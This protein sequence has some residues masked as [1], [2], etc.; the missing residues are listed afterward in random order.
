MKKKIISLAAVMSMIITLVMP[1]A[2]YAD[3][4][5]EESTAVLKY[6][7][8]TSDSEEWKEVTDGET[9]GT[10][11]DDAADITK[12][13]LNVSD[14]KSQE[15]QKTVSYAVADTE[16]TWSDY[17]AAGQE[18]A[19]TSGKAV[20]AVK[21]KVADELA[22]KYDIYYRAYVKAEENAPGKWL[23]WAKNDQ[24][25]GVKGYD[26][27]IKAIQFQLVEKDTENTLD[28]ANPFLEKKNE[29]PEEPTVPTGTRDNSKGSISGSCCQDW[30]AERS[31]RWCTRRNRRK[32][33]YNRS[34]KDQ[35]RW[36]FRRRT[37]RQQNCLQ[38]SCTDLWLAE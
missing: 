37:E 2:V 8:L 10:A 24:V 1:A 16:G 4:P 14:S 34:I 12:L 7:V 33:T 28:T 13:K 22:E 27:G 25:S 30:L 6:S 9:A 5:Q 15:D 32:S 17:I 26:C 20:A 36:S 19:N 35:T 23:G 3:E 29:I 11:A 38:D 18:A 21:A 31:G